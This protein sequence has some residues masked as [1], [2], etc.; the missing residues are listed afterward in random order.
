M[1]K[2]FGTKGE[3]RFRLYN[4]DSSLIKDEGMVFLSFA[5]EDF[6]PFRIDKV[7]FV[8]KGIIIKFDGI[9]KR[10]DAERLRGS[11][12]YVKREH[13]PPLDKDEFYLTDLLKSDVY[14]NNGNLI[15][16]VNWFFYN[17]AHHILVVKGDDKEVWVPFV[18]DAV[19]DV[20]DSK[21]IID[22]NFCVE[23]S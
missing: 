15:G 21:I 7:R 19:L 3:L 4:P 12:V 5:G 16:K 17:G 20:E 10:E 6:K 14:D 13:L 2:P 11:F 1:T 8:E 18:K 9:D 23:Q 22:L